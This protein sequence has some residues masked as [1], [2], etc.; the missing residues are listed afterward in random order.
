MF[1]MQTRLWGEYLTHVT[2]SDTCFKA[3][4]M[5]GTELVKFKFGEC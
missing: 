4:H 2:Q 3:L 5:H 1:R